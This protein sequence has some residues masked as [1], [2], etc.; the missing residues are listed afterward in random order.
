MLKWMKKL[1]QWLGKGADG[2]KKVQTYRLLLLVGLIGLAFMLIN[3]FINVKHVEP[4]GAGREP[5]VMQELTSGPLL[6][7]DGGSDSPFTQIELSLENKTKEI[8]EKIVGVGEVDVMVTVDSTEEIIVQRNMRDTQE[9][10]EEADADGG[11]RNITQYSRDGEIVTYEASGNEQPIVTK[12]IKPKVRGVL[13]VAR[14]A[15]NKVVKGL[16]VD[17]VEKGLNVPAYRISVV[18]RKQSQ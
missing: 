7:E 14:G 5:P 12:K 11:T 9:M 16:I 17:A 3:S 15:E 8:L 1:E 10:T 18:P 6:Q 13:I 4:D 2:K